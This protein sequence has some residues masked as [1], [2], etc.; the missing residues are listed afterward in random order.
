MRLN[1]SASWYDV[2]C[3]TAVGIIP[4][5]PAAQVHWLVARVKDL[6]KFI[7]VRGRAVAIPVHVQGRSHD[8]I[9]FHGRRLRT[10]D[11]GKQERRGSDCAQRKAEKQCQSQCP[12]THV[13]HPHMRHSE[14]V[15]RARLADITDKRLPFLMGCQGSNPRR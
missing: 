6:H 7:L 11:R 4:Q 3:R 10:Q 2:G 12:P 5:H 15:K 13:P 9:E 8:L 1:Q 14:T